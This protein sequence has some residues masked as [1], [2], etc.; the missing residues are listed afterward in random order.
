MN[1]YRINL[2]Y[3]KAL[4]MLAEERV[5]GDIVAEDMRLVGKVCGENRELGVVF[6]NPTIPSAKKL[7]L[8]KG[9]F[10][11][12]VSED[13]LAFLNFVVKKSRSVHLRG[14]SEAYLTLW[15]EARGIVL[16]ELVTH[17]PVD[18]EA[19]RGVM[20]VVSAYTGKQVEL[21]D[22]TDVHMVG[23]FKLEFDHNM[24]DARLRT[25]LRKLRMEFA[26]NEYESKL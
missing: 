5:H 14:I 11:G 9:L 15:R 8:V 3:A 26:K 12:R 7:A 6:A 16:S 25:K 18:D 23:G 21:N 24:Y 1:S 2:N 22:H 4:F 20:A 17:Q 13:T 10:E 19:R